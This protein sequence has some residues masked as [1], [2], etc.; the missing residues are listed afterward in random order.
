MGERSQGWT[1]N[2][3]VL[4]GSDFDLATV[5]PPGHVASLAWTALSPR[6]TT[7]Q[8]TLALMRSQSI[9]EALVAVE[10]LRSNIG[11]EA[12][13]RVRVTTLL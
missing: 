11:C 10:D 3:P 8:A 12:A 4:P 2:G 1:D 7:I 6:D 9:D 13:Q 5:T